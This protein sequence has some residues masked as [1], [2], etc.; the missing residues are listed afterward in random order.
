MRTEP[1]YLTINGLP[2]VPVMLFFSLF[3][4]DEKIEGK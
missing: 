3:I 4:F 2:V 1:Y